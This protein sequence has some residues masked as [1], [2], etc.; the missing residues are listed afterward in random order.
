MVTFTEGNV[1]QRLDIDASC[2]LSSYRC[3]FPFRD[4]FPLLTVTTDL[5]LDLVFMIESVLGLPDLLLG[6]AIF[7]EVVTE[8]VHCHDMVF[9]P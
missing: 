2:L 3:C 4:F 8:L 5:L 6:L 1:M 9:L 7:K